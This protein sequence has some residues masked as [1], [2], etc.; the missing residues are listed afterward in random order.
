MN[1]SFIV[2]ADDYGLS[3][4]FNEGILD[5]A[6]SGL[7][8]GISVMIEREYI[9]PSVSTTLLNVSL[10]LHLEI[11]DEAPEA[12][13][14][15]QIRLFQDTFHAPPTHL[16]GHQHRHLLPE[17]LPATIE[18]AKRH[19]IPVRSRFDEDR[20][21]LRDA[22]IHTP[23]L[24]ISWHPTR[25]HMFLEKIEKSEW[26][27]EI[28]C[29]PGYYDAD[30]DYPYNKYREQEL[31]IMKKHFPRLRGSV[32]GYREISDYVRTAQT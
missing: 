2:T 29:H 5:A 21:I 4:K 23:D 24:F 25:V 14:E 30:S 1:A 11:S 8:S 32:I 12:A 7:I 28:V 10:G 9:D 16:D 17:N 27:V 31:R 20:A 22:G 6:Q 19:G 26:L 15:R 18:A 3:P 13:I